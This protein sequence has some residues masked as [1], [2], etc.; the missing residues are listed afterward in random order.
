[1]REHM[2]GLAVAFFLVGC[3]GSGSDSAAKAGGGTSAALS[4]ATEATPET[5]PPEARPPEAKSESTATTIVVH[6]R[7]AGLPLSDGML[8]VTGPDGLLPEALARDPDALFPRADGSLH[9]S[10]PPGQYRLLAVGPDNLRAESNVAVGE[11]LLKL[12]MELREDEAAL[13]EWVERG[14]GGAR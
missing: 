10:L 3:G 13:Q 14:P 2:L 5:R 4:S 8:V 6:L 7:H 9:L 12:S 11:D 1:M